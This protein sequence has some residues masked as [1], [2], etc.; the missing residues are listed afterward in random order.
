MTLW[1]FVVCTTDHKSPSITALNKQEGALWSH[2][3]KWHACN[4]SK[5][6][7]AY[8]SHDAV[9]LFCNVTLLWR[10]SNGKYQNAKT[11]SPWGNRF[12]TPFR[13]ATIIGCDA[14]VSPTSWTTGCDEAETMASNKNMVPTDRLDMLFNIKKQVCVYIY[15]HVITYSI[16]CIGQYYN[17]ISLNLMFLLIVIA[18][19]WFLISPCCPTPR[20]LP[21]GEPHC[22]HVPK[23]STRRWVVQLIYINININI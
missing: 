14:P 21:C 5:Y 16:V 2:V 10:G 9:L 11:L 12:L 15:I 4:I 17:D 23:R 1:I 18:S 3:C 19:Q 6:D 22:R 20:G 7:F 13:L 8:S